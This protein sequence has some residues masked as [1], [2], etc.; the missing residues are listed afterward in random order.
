[1]PNCDA[2]VED[3]EYVIEQFK[4]GRFDYLEVASKVVEAEF[5]RFFLNGGHLDRLAASYPTPRKKHDV[6]L[7]VYLSSQITLKLH[8]AGGFA[9]LPYILYCGGLVDALGHRQAQW[10]EDAGAGSRRLCFEGYNRKNQYERST[11][12]DHDF[13]RKLSRDTLAPA[14]QYW[15]SHAV[16]RLYRDLGAFDSDGIFM[17]DGSYLFVPDNP[18]YEESAVIWFDEHN[19]PIGKEAREKLTPAARK[20]CRLRRC[21]RSVSLIH[22]DRALSHTLYS[23]IRLLPGNAS[24][25][26]YLGPLVDDFIDAL[27]SMSETSSRDAQKFE[28]S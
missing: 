16:N 20:R 7:W 6:P 2:F 21:Y 13:L 3:K 28:L 5:F 8:G 27:D 24:E 17:V 11:P 12:C 4:A 23:G 26:P 18:R 10:R 25:T 22:T 9:A 14:L 15:F 1:M 19:H